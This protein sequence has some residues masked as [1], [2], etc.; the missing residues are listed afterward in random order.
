MNNTVTFSDNDH[1]MKNAFSGDLFNSPKIKSVVNIDS[2]HSPSVSSNRNKMKK[3]YDDRM[4]K[5]YKPKKLSKML[6]K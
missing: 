6:K 5:S 3:S 2:P 1:H 4:I